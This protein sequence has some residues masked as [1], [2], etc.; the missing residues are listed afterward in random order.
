MQI[1]PV[2]SVHRNRVYH[3]LAINSTSMFYEVEIVQI[4]YTLIFNSIF[5]LYIII[6]TNNNIF[7]LRISIFEIEL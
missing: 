2:G 4:K 7:K 1:P 6:F 3:L 5:L